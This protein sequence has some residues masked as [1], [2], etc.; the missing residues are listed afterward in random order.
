MDDKPRPIP[1][2]TRATAAQRPCHKMQQ[3]LKHIGSGIV[4][5][6][7]M[8]VILIVLLGLGHLVGW[9]PTW[10]SFG[11]TPLS[12]HFF[13]MRVVV[14]QAACALKGF[15]PY[16]VNPCYPIAGIDLPP[17]WLW[18]GYLGID[19]S[20]A[21]WLAPL[22]ILAALGVMTALMKG[23]S[24][25]FGLLASI[26]ILSPSVMMGIER[27]NVD[28]TIFSLVGAAAL[29]F[30]EQRIS[31]IF[32]AI[33]L[34]AFAFVLKLFPMF[35]VALASRFNRHTLLFAVAIGVL[36]VIYLMLISDYIPII[37]HTA[38]TTFILSYGYKAL[39][40]GLDHLR[41]E[42]GL[43]P[44]GLTDT[45]LPLALAVLTVILAALVAAFHFHYGNSVCTVSNRVAGTAFLFGAGIYCGTFL[46]GTNFIYRLMFL[47]LCLPQLHEW[48]SETFYEK[49]RTPT[50]GYG[51]FALVL[52]A[53]WSN[54]NANGHSTFTLMPQAVNW[55][56]FFGLTTILC[57]NLLNSTRA[58]LSH[59]QLELPDY[60]RNL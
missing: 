12:P 60:N 59:S 34:V 6:G 53:L 35:C 38:P 4:I 22:E 39:F 9:D 57:L 1:V 13:D 21:A 51:L 46:L 29:I 47:L 7:A 30:H 20:D 50:I 18:L 8:L 37:R 23:R 49:D 54:G 31:R 44:I 10:R 11:V 33:A 41:S 25:T 58:R 27:G 17:V 28:L 52:M 42:G 32:Y 5:A 19:G 16:E 14:A 56:L 55:L 45:W 36:S 2:H 26:A 24:I 43:G 48:A 3:R 15:S 40:L